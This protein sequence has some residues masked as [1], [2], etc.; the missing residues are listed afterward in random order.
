V[1]TIGLNTWHPIRV[2][3]SS[4]SSSPRFLPLV[5]FLSPFSAT[6]VQTK[7]LSFRAIDFETTS[8]SVS[9]GESPR[10]NGSAFESKRGYFY[11][12]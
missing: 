11:V 2:L 1:F 12:R 6:M 4:L 10:S 8:K 5:N 3:S 7:N 9:N